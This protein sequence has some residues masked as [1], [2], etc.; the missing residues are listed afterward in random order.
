MTMMLFTARLQ[1]LVLARTLVIASRPKPFNVITSQTRTKYRKKTCTLT[2]YMRKSS[3]L[4]QMGLL[5]IFRVTFISTIHKFNALWMWYIT[6]WSRSKKSVSSCNYTFSA[7]QKL[8]NLV[9]NAKYY[10]FSSQKTE[11]S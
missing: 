6:V 2:M 4:F 9:K 10:F 5:Q 7:N 11:R 3:I 1:S 8:Y